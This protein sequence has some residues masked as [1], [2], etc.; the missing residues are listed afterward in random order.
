MKKAVLAIILLMAVSVILISCN[1]DTGENPSGD[2]IENPGGDI[3]GNP[4]DNPGGDVIENP[5]GDI[6]GNPGDNPG[7]DVTENP[8]PEVYYT[9][10]FDAQGGSEMSAVKVKEGAVVGGVTLP[11]KQCGSFVGFAKDAYGEVMWN[12]FRDTVTGNITLY[13]IWDAAH[14]WST[15]E[16][17]TEPTCT[18]EGMQKRICEVCGEEDTDIIPALGHDFE[19][20]YTVDAEPDCETKGSESRHCTR[21]DA[22]TDSREIEALGHTWGEWATETE[23]TCTAEGTR[24]RICEVCGKE[25]TDSI[26]ALGHDFEDEYTVDAEPDCITK[27]SESRHCTR[28]DATTDSREIEATGHTWSAWETVT[29]PTCTVEGT[30]KRIC[31]VCGEEETDSISALGHDFVI[32][33][34][35]ENY[36]WKIC[37]RCG[38]IS[39]KT[40]HVYDVVGKCECGATE[41]TPESEFTFSNLGDNNWSI[42]KYNGSRSNVNIPSSY[43]DGI[44]VSIGFSAFTDCT[45]LTL[46]TIPDSINSIGDY[47]FNNCTGLTSVTIGNSVTSIGDYAFYNCTGLTSVTIG[48]SVTSIG[49]YAFSGCTKLTLLNYNGDIAGWCGID[50]LSDIM[51]SGVTLHIGGQPLEDELIIPDSVTEIN[52]Y[53]FSNCTGLTSVTIPDSLHGTYFGDD[54]RLGHE[55]RKRCILG[56]QFAREHNHTFR[57]SRSG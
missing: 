27:G 5:D 39:D 46:L 25:E 6:G 32:W 35:D 17:V 12:L 44:V 16:A 19:E 48:N 50:G 24:K 13:A 33:E 42:V 9:V 1:S 36:H 29:E 47:A 51:S 57:G 18:A 52:S 34:Y 38:A 43:N 41:I 54:T 49:S 30:R 3:G 20:E 28:C 53:I 55:H 14:T 45:E 10:T 56:L 7:G 26:P 15:W 11:T 23:P 2:V 8:E 40:A 31:E 21:C 37:S 4:G 22:T